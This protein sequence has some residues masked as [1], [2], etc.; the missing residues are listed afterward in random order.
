MN[1]RVDDM[2]KQFRSANLYININIVSKDE[3]L[4]NEILF[5]CMTSKDIKYTFHTKTFVDDQTLLDHLKRYN[6]EILLTELGI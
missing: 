3:E 4:V 5:I 2:H 6:R 1:N